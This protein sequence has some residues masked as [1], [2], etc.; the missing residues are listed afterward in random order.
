MLFT[1]NETKELQA[2]LRTVELIDVASD[3]VSCSDAEEIAAKLYV[4][5]IALYDLNVKTEGDFMAMLDD[6]N[7]FTQKEIENANNVVTDWA[8]THLTNL[9]I[10]EKLD[11]ILE[12]SG[13]NEEHIIDGFL[14]LMENEQDYKQTLGLFNAQDYF[15]ADDLAELDRFIESAKACNEPFTAEHLHTVLG[16]HIPLLG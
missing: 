11:F 16:G 9:A 7:Q 4:P 1:Q 3:F 14:N 10:E 13:I 5:S 12:H 15:G 2:I 8:L 6:E